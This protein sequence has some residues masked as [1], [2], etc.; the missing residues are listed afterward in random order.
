MRTSPLKFLQRCA[1]AAI[2]SREPLA[3]A[4]D[5]RRTGAGLHAHRPH[6]QPARPQ[7]VQRPGRHGEFLGHLVRS[8]PAGNAA[9]SIRCTR[10]TSRPA[11]R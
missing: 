4:G 8:L 9:C 7:P 3:A 1:M 2:L 10:S 6:G 5:A 11:S